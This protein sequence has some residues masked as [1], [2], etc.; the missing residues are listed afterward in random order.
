MAEAEADEAVH[1][2]TP[3]LLRRRARARI[4]ADGRRLQFLGIDVGGTFTDAV[5][6]ADGEVRTAKVPTRGARRSRCSR[7]LRRS[8]ADE[9]DRFTH[10]TTIATN[11]LLER[12]GARTAFVTTAGFEHLLHLRRQTRAHLYR[13]CAE[14][15]R[16]ARPARALRR[17][18]RAHRAGRR[19][20]A[21]RPGV[22]AR[23]RRRR[24]RRL[25]PL[26]VPGRRSTSGRSR[27]S[28]GAAIR[29]RTSSPR[30]RSRPSSASTSGPRRP[31]STRTSG[32][33]SRGYLARALR[34][35]PRGR[36]RRAARHALVRRRGDAR[37]SRRS[38]RRWRC[39][40]ALRRES[41]ALRESRSSPGSRTRSRSTWA[42]RRRTS[43][44]SSTA[45]HGASTSGRRRLSGAASDA[46]GA[47]GRG[48]RRLDRVAG[49]GRR[50]C[51]SAPR[52]RGLIPGRRATG[53]A[54]PG[55]R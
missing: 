1:S 5:L 14:H 37:G 41:S 13:P 52:A 10:G 33:C 21:A 40:R 32:P 26:L 30:T 54:E 49:L 29:R 9:V 48:G 31:S 6:V 24:D 3:T 18:A 23:A 46:R 43:A 7:P 55:R 53:T 22:A 44:P 8:G 34:G 2:R 36:A 39:S 12:R 50:A 15:P 35:V 28:F 42:G 47:H 45:R 16:A 51:G 11:A 17:R 4:R 25:P 27:A 20:R 19:A 38:T